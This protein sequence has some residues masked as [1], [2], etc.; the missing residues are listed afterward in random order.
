MITNFF[1]KRLLD[2]NNGYYMPDVGP[3]SSFVATDVIAPVYQVDDI[4]L[5]ILE[6]GE[7]K[8]QMASHCLKPHSL[9]TA[10]IT[11]EVVEST[12]DSA[13]KSWVLPLGMVRPWLS[14]H[15]TVI[16]A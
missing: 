12:L 11:C 7:G 5:L 6:T 15:L 14:N 13:F 4:I 3:R 9:P 2:K 8:T 16:L 10:A 1:L